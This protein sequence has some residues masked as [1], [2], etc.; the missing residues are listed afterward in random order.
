MLSVL[1][2]ALTIYHEA[3][4]EPLLGQKLVAQV[5]LN[6]VHSSRY[7]DT[8]CEVVK[9][10]KQFSF[11]THKGYA[12]IPSEKRAWQVAYD[13]AYNA[14]DTHKP[15][16]VMYYHKTSISV[17]WAANLQKH[18]VVGDHVFYTDRKITRP[19]TR[20]DTIKENN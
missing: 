10:R 11:V 6:R 8:V 15:S 7:P 17:K 12:P 2:L 9:E 16:R 13:L 4:S 5:V 3:R 18:L 20:P 19:I 1:C 14:L